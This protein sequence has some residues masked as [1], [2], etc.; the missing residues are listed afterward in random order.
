MFCLLIID[1]LILLPFIA[2]LSF[3]II[4][5]NVLAGARPLLS[6]DDDCIEGYREVI[7]RCW[8]NQ[9]DSRLHFKGK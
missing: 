2:G 8:D 7:T 3:F 1:M 6:D 5:D 4:Q 9:P